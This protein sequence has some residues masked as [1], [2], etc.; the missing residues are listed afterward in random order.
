MVARNFVSSMSGTGFAL[1]YSASSK[2]F[3]FTCSAAA[4]RPYSGCAVA[5]FREFG[6]LSSTPRAN[7]RICSTL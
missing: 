4:P 5:N 7:I 3:A 6:N 1:N 2:N